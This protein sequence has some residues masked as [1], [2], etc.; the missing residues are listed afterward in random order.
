MNK[1]IELYPKN[2]LNIINFEEVYGEKPTVD[3]A[4]PMM[5]REFVI[6]PYNSMGHKSNVL[7][8]F[9]NTFNLPVD[10][11]NTEYVVNYYMGQWSN[12]V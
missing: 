2:Y 12:A 7:S 4:F 5:V 10:S 3:N 8:K 1:T 11:F 9:H 6:N